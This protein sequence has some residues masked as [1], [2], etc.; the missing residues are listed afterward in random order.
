M[1]NHFEQRSR[2]ENG[3]RMLPDWDLLRPVKVHQQDVELFEQRSRELF[4]SIRTFQAM[5]ND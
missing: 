1:P 5:D 3:G 2:E 4:P